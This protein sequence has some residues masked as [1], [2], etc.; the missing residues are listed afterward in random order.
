MQCRRLIAMCY[1]L[2]RVHVGSCQVCTG[3]SWAVVSIVDEVV[4]EVV[5]AELLYNQRPGS[6]EMLHA[7]FYFQKA[8]YL[9][10][11]GE[12]PPN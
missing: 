7:P 2:S 10:Q 1:V 11:S 8:V 4:E 3:F 5:V 6:C 12:S 9:P